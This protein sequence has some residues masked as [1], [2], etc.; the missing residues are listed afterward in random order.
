MTVPEI[1]QYSRET[2]NTSSSM[3]N[4]SDASL[5]PYLNMVYKTVVG[6]IIDRVGEAYFV[7]RF[8][9]DLVAWQARYQWREST[10][11]QA[12]FKN[13]QE[14]T[15]KRDTT[16]DNYQ[17]LKQRDNRDDYVS[18]TQEATDLSTANGYYE[19]EWQY[20]RIYPTPLNTVTD[21]IQVRVT[22]NVIDLVVDWAE[23]TIFPDHTELRGYHDILMYWLRPIIYQIKGQINE[24]N[25]AK[26]EFAMELEKFIDNIKYKNDESIVVELPSLSYYKS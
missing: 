13:I 3:T 7:G 4:L 17:V 24:K 6:T 21:G 26:Q 16:D 15:V 5:L 23:T 8:S 10:S 14:L 22:K 2:T 11:I 12:W 19:I 20:L 9:D 18:D 1:L 25:D